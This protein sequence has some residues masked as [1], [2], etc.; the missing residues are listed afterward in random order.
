MNC[1]TQ[2][3]VGHDV[4]LL[5]PAQAARVA[6]AEPPKGRAARRSTTPPA[7]W[8]VER[9]GGATLGRFRLRDPGGLLRWLEQPDVV[10]YPDWVAQFTV[11]LAVLVF[12][13]VPTPSERVRAIEAGRIATVLRPAIERAAL[14][15]PD[16]RVTGPAF[17]GAF[18]A[19]VEELARRWEAPAQTCRVR[20]RAGVRERQ[21]RISP[22]ADPSRRCTMRTCR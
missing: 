8:V 5:E 9:Q 10:S 11:G 4:G 3:G 1:A 17:T 2:S 12:L 21:A 19:W 16:L 13:E 6:E 15:G 14:P 20:A 22:E 18:D 7:P